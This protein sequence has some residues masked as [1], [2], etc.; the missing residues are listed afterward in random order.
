MKKDFWWWNKKKQQLDKRR[1]DDIFPEIKEIW[2]VSLW[3]NVWS[4]QNGRWWFLRPVL[5]IKRIG[6]LYFCIPLSSQYKAHRLY[7]EIDSFHYKNKISF[8]LLG[9]WRVLDKKRFLRLLWKIEEEEYQK[10]KKLIKD[11]YIGQ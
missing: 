11:L 8:L 4:E 7:Y 1:T 2:Y 10:I 6:G 9:Q 5:I 3:V